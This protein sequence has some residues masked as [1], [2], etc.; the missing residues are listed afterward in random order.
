[1]R[2][3]AL[4]KCLSGMSPRQWY[5]SLNRRVFF[6]ATQKRLLT[7]LSAKA[8]RDR[9]HGVIT[10]DTAGLLERHFDQVN[11]SPI[12]SGSAIY[13][14]QPRGPETSYHRT[15]IHSSPEE[16]GTD[17]RTQLRSSQLIMQSLIS[18]KS[19]LASK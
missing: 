2:E 6:W 4:L 5:E 8:Y 16:R 17:D 9:K 7:L 11:L 19:R 15:H 10:V 1:M 13:T 18:Q 3:S 12:N 14:P